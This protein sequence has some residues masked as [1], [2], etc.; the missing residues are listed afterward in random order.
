MARTRRSA[1]NQILNNEGGV[2]QTALDQ[3]VTQ[4]VADVL[5]AIEANRSST[6]EETN[7]TSTTTH[8]CYYKEF[9]SYMQG[10]FSGTEGAVR[11]TRWFEKLKCVF[12]VSKVE[13]GDRAKY[14]VKDMNIIAYTQRFQELAL[15]C[16]IKRYIGGLS[17]NIKGNVTSSKPT[18]IHET[19]TMAHSLMDQVIQDLVG[20]P[21]IT[22]DLACPLAITVERKAK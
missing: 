17:Q 20:V 3:L 21:V 10:N 12:R 5:A 13:D 8:I 1:T 22:M 14:A 6:Q 18:D 11:L 4:R 2:N 16:Q 7:K 9:R 19:I 15:L